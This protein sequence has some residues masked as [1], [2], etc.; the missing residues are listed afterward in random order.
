MPLESFSEDF[1]LTGRPVR[2]EQY[3]EF[4]LCFIHK[5]KTHT[6]GGDQ[7]E[8]EFSI[9]LHFY[10]AGRRHS[11]VSTANSK[12]IL[13][14]TVIKAH[15]AAAQLQGLGLCALHNPGPG[16]CVLSL[17]IESFEKIHLSLVPGKSSLPSLHV[18]AAL[19]FN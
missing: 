5:R 17:W 1:P 6:A 9:A 2:G 14:H 7:D 3:C 15:G 19:S 11:N 10:E 13:P 18:F 4:D 8:V 12:R 16:V